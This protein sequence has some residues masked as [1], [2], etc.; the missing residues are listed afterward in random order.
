MKEAIDFYENTY[1]NTNN[2][3]SKE[4]IWDNYRRDLWN[5][6]KVGTSGNTIT[7]HWTNIGGA[8]GSYDQFVKKDGIT[9]V[10][11]FDGNAQYPGHPS[12]RYTVRNS[13]YK[14]IKTEELWKQ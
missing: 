8:G 6:V 14:V 1:K 3:I 12:M 13:D 9:E 7:L 2:E 4:I 5:L 11:F 10:T